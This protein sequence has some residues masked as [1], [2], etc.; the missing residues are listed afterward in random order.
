VR[1]RPGAQLSCM[2]PGVMHRRLDHLLFDK[3]HQE[4]HRIYITT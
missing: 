1:V 4:H 2:V 3:E